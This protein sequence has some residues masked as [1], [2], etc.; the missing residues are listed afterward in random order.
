MID[1]SRPSPL[2]ASPNPFYQIYEGAA[3]LAGAEPV[4]LNQT[5]ADGFALDLDSISP[6]SSG[7]ASSCCTCARPA[8]PT[9][10]V[11]TLD[12]WRALFERSDRY[13][14]VI[15]SD[16]CYSEI[17]D[18]EQAPPIGGLEAA[19]Q[20]GR[21]DFGTWSCSPVCRNDRMR[22]ACAPAAVAG[23]ADLLRQFLLYRTYHGCAMSLAVQHASIAAW[24]D[25][26]HVVENRGAL[27]RE[28]R[29]RRA[30]AEPV[31]TRPSRMPASISGR[32]TPEETT[33]VCAGA[34]RGDARDRAAGT[35]SGREAHGD[36]SGT[37]LRAHRARARLD[38]CVEAAR[39]IVEFCR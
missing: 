21:D 10:R 8:I 30:D 36:E 32:G 24:S 4:F 11:L 19:H 9:G 15:A 27:P 23:D 18:D 6:T 16:E 7:R 31:L 29:R 17:Y 34:V 14:F 5:T 3:L 39:R 12:D 35:V 28:V 13:G 1:A 20:L 26:A 2:V 22:R 33:S 25:E 38:D 37:R